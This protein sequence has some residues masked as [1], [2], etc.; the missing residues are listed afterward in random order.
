VLWVILQDVRI[1]NTGS[2]TTTTYLYGLGLIAETDN[3]GST[4]FY[5]SDGL[6][7]TSDVVESDGDVA[8][9][10][11]Y[12]VWG[13]IRSSSGSVAN[14]FD[15]TGEQAD[16]NANRGLVYL[17]ARFYDPALGRFLSRDPLPLGNRYAYS[18]NNPT[19]FIDPLGLLQTESQF[20]RPVPVP[21]PTP[22]PNPPVSSGLGCID[23]HIPGFTC[24]LFP[25][26]ADPYAPF[27]NLY[28]SAK[29]IWNNDV[30]NVIRTCVVFTRGLEQV[31]RC[32]TNAVVRG[33]DTTALDPGELRPGEGLTPTPEP[34]MYGP[35]IPSCEG[36]F[37]EELCNIFREP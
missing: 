12:D 11:T 25:P 16:H 10:Y 28:N 22:H 32:F 4:F 31:A 29:A 6:G 1:P 2:T 17:R 8:N 35:P 24:S 9:T 18:G 20:N 7:S 26:G 27:I 14:Q 13:A 34:P 23:N 15:F 36:V 21:A 30:T 19:N 3:D 37:S 33:L 5:L